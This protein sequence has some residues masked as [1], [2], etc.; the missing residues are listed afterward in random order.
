MSIT[1]LIFIRY[2]SFS[3]NILFTLLLLLVLFRLFTLLV[4]FTL[5]LEILFEFSSRIDKID[6]T[7][8][9]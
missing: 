4:L 3:W 7:S 8:G 1:S 6:S 9:L 2:F 5:V